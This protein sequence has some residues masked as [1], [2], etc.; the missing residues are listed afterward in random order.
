VGAV[1]AAD[2]AGSG[3]DIEADAGD[4]AGETAIAV[5]E[6]A[7]ASSPDARPDPWQ[8]LMQVGV[9]FVTALASSNDPRAPAHPWIE[10]DAKTGAQN[11]KMPLPPPEAARKIADA[12]SGLADMLRGRVG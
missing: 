3:E 12:L 2:D 5:A 4:V 1:V 9:Q 10:R 11:L 6:G 8:A 7:G